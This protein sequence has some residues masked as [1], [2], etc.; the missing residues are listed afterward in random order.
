MGAQGG[1]G[2]IEED[3]PT[4]AGGRDEGTE[5]ELV[6]HFESGEEAVAPDQGAHVG[7]ERI[8]LD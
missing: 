8:P 5:C 1:R 3:G 6:S 7:P 4:E 2:L